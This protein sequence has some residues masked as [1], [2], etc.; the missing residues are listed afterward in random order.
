MD[1]YDLD[2]DTFHIDG[3]P[4]SLEVEDIYFIIGLSHRGEIFNL[5]ARGLGGGL[6]ID[7][8]IV[9]YFLLDTE[10]V[11]SQVP[12]NSIQNLVLKAI[13]LAL[14]RIMGLA[15]LHKDSRPLMFYTFEC[16]RST[17]YE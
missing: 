6:T 10:K 5:R 2:T 4:L 11:G 16:M 17:I 15:S 9:V 8:Y 7:E 12:M 1:Y 13:V 3:I 14:S